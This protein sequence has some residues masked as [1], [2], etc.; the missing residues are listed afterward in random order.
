[1]LERLEGFLKQYF[2]NDV[3]MPVKP[4]PPKDAAGA[5]AKNPDERHMG[6]IY[7]WGRYDADKDM[8]VYSGRDWMILLK[9]LAVVDFD[10]LD[11]IERW[12]AE[13]PELREAAM[14]TT[15]KGRHYFFRRPSGFGAVEA[16]EACESQQA[17]NARKEAEGW[18][19]RKTHLEEAV[20]L[21]TVTGS[22]VPHPATGRLFLT[23]GTVVVAPSA[24]KTWV[25]PLWEVGA[26]DMSPALQRKI[27]GLVGRPAK[28][29][30]G[31]PPPPA[32][33]P[34]T[35]PSGSSL[36][37]FEDYVAALERM[38]FREPLL[39]KEAEDYLTFDAAN[40]D[41]A[42]P[43][44]K[45]RTHESQRWK[46]FVRSGDVRVNS[47]SDSCVREGV[48]LE[49]TR[50]LGLLPQV[51]KERFGFDE[52]VYAGA[53]PQ[54]VLWEFDVTH[55]GLVKKAVVDRQLMS[56]R[57]PWGPTATRFF[58]DSVDHGLEIH[59]SIHN[60]ETP[61]DMVFTRQTEREASLL[62]KS[63]GEAAWRLELR[64]F[65]GEDF[66]V[67]EHINGRWSMVKLTKA[68]KMKVHQL[69]ERAHQAQL[70]E[71]FGVSPTLIINNVQ[72]NNYY[73]KCVFT[74]S[75][76]EPQGDER[77][78]DWHIAVVMEGAG[79]FADIKCVNLQELYRFCPDTGFWGVRDKDFIAGKM[80][81]W[82]AESQ[83][84]RDLLNAKT[85]KYLLS[86][87]GALS[88]L[89]A[90]SSELMEFDFPQTLDNL[91][92]GHIPFDNGMYVLGTGFR[93]FTRADRVTRGIGYDYRPREQVPSEHFE[94][95]ERFYRE[96]FPVEAE[97]TYFWRMMGHALLGANAEKAFLVMT[98]VR[99]GYNAKTTV[100]RLQEHTF[101][102]LAARTQNS[103]LYPA[104]HTD[105]NAA[106]PT[107]LQY[108]GKKLAFF[109]EPNQ[110]QQ[111][112]IG[113]IKELTGG[114][115]RACARRNFS[116]VVEDFE[117]RAFIVV[118]ANENGLPHV[119]SCDGAFL[120][121][122]NVL[123]MRAKVRRP[124]PA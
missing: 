37:P 67:F 104:R 74:N 47:W 18:V 63:R 121:R 3:L 38:G 44:C 20:D 54:P 42:C 55:E 103:F 105:P 116:N 36:G 5:A 31:A 27:L 85:I 86:N 16:M 71:G 111:L 113:K 115:A 101:G 75:V 15:R 70:T 112:D 73:H 97:R 80:R 94:V 91:P 61:K 65:P 79:F 26:R 25:R 110:N 76:P 4:P 99:D 9:D 87:K 96:V 69:V 117:F 41:G 84:A 6:G 34:R 95:L 72:Q 46:L 83:E 100:M 30:R 24:N 1:M 29:S 59:G 77:L 108:A 124:R 122:M 8:N 13:F 33:R 56:V 64:D 35:G 23:A 57:G 11:P 92:P 62:S 43:V 78:E 12:E 123:P 10:R 102:N 119:N 32:K 107:M 39:V 60:V 28:R 68:A 81:K 106:N 21:L 109:E 118:A 88:V 14:E 49:C 98:D 7:T 58:Y 90:F 120:A 82:A 93:P 50:L 22:L 114:D 51:M 19:V 89:Q 2:P 45:E 66:N 17:L 48:V 52:V 40:H 53:G